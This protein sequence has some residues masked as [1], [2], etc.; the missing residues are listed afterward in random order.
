MKALQNRNRFAAAC[1]AVLLISCLCISSCLISTALAQSSNWQ[2]NMQSNVSATRV[3]EGVTVN[4]VGSCS[5]TFSLASTGQQVTGSGS[6]TVVLSASGSFDDYESTGTFTVPQRSMPC[7][8]SISGTV[9]SDA[10]A[11]LTL[12]AQIDAPQ[13]LE[14]TATVTNSDGSTSIEPFEV[15]ISSLN[16]LFSGTQTIKLQDGYSDT[17]PVNSAG[18]SG[19]VT[20]SVTGTGG[21]GQ[22][23]PSGL[24]PLPSGYVMTP[25]DQANHNFLTNVLHGVEVYA[26]KAK[27]FVTFT[28]EMA[29]AQIMSNGVATIN[30]VTYTFG[31]ESNDRIRVFA[32]SVVTDKA[33]DVALDFVKTTF[34]YTAP[35]ITL[36]GH[37]G[38]AN[39]A[40]E[41][42]NTFMEFNQLVND[43]TNNARVDIGPFTV[44]AKLPTS[45]EGLLNMYPELQWAKD[46]P[47]SLKFLQV[48]IDPQSQSVT[49]SEPTDSAV[50]LSQGTVSGT[51]PLLRSVFAIGFAAQQGA[52]VEDIVAEA[53]QQPSSSPDAT[54]SFFSYVWVIG[55]VA[56]LAVVVVVVIIVVRP[57]KSSDS[58]YLPPPLPDTPPPPP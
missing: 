28:T 5:S 7:T 12:T 53:A 35:V 51:V 49:V 17:K 33:V 14:G 47:D 34:P 1:L 45:T 2:V 16:Q 56:V 15:P 36:A 48:N 22:P 24:V 25:E 32:Q 6:G 27:P 52:V 13:T 50:D 26:E 57:R 3:V 40:Y 29:R 21:Q 11:T 44:T 4:V 39:T 31:V 46:H 18:V 37:A 8:Y 20:F 41:V 30:G 9:A 38:S 23:T 54:A 55:L 19:S 43:P 42:Y 10:T 58:S